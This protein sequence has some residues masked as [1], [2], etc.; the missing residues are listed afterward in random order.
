M[1]PV[2]FGQG[3]NIQFVDIEL[4]CA[5]EA[6][7]GHTCA[8]VA[9]HG[10]VVDFALVCAEEEN[11]HTGGEE[12]DGGSCTA[13]V[14][15][16]IVI[17]D[18]VVDEGV[19]RNFGGELGQDDDENACRVAVGMVVV[20]F[21]AE[22]VLQFD[23][24][25]I[26]VGDAVAHDDCF[27][28]TRVNARVVR[29]CHFDAFDEDVGALDGINAVGACLFGED[30]VVVDVGHAFDED[31][32]IGVVADVEIADGEVVARGDDGFGEVVFAI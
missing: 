19:A 11:A 30:V 22:G 3:T 4:A 13:E 7:D 28:L 21:A 6:E 29:A 27:A 1:H 14:L 9:A 17:G 26:A 5:G 24:N 16:V 23:A 2:A 15:Q 25:H 20:D 18:V 10:V 32:V 8:F 31:A 12:A